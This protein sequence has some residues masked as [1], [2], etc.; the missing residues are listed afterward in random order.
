ML[1]TPLTTSVVATITLVTPVDVIVISTLVVALENTVDGFNCVMVLKMVDVLPPE[2]TVVN[3]D[4]V[5]T[6]TLVLV[7]CP[8]LVIVV[9]NK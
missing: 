6:P 5:V 3:T 9:G 4:V 7:A 1:V 8:V 2:T